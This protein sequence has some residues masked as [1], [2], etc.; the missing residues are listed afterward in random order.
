MVDSVDHGLFD[1]SKREV[2]EPLGF[3]AVRMFDDRLL[4]VVSF[5]KQDRIAGDLRERSR[6]YLLLELVAAGTFGKPD[7]VDLGGGEELAGL[8]VEEQQSDVARQRGLCRPAHHIH[9]PPEVLWGHV[10]QA[11]DERAADLA[12]ELGHQPERE[13]TDIRL[14]VQT[15]IVWHGGRQADQLP[16]VFTPGFDGA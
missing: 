2:P 5:D 16:L 13:V 4:Q 14:T 11:I 9:L 8:V 1:G 12:K 3:R 7:H 10:V 15:I 6:E